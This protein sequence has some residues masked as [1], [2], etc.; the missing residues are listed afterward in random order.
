MIKTIIPVI[1]KPS[2]PELLAVIFSRI[3]T[4]FRVNDESESYFFTFHEWREIYET[5]QVP[6]GL[7]AMKPEIVTTQIPIIGRSNV[8]R[9]VSFAE[10]E[11]LTSYILQFETLSET[12]EQRQKRLRQL[13]HFYMK[14]LE[15]AYKVEWV[16]V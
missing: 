3:D 14:N 12:G 8:P 13:G 4:N 1:Y 6:D 2:E 5:V 11:A 9:E 16:E 7:G 10:V 15:D